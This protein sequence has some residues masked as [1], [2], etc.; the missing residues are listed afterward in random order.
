MGE[1]LSINEMNE[2]D[3][4]EQA[5]WLQAIISEVRHVLPAAPSHPFRQMSYVRGGA[6]FSLQ[7]PPYLPG[8]ERGA[9]YPASS[10]HFWIYPDATTGTVRARYELW[11]GSDAY[12]RIGAYENGPFMYGHTQLAGGEVVGQWWQ[13]I[14]DRLAKLRQLI[15]DKEEARRQEQDRR[16]RQESMGGVCRVCVVTMNNGKVERCVVFCSEKGLG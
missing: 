4:T 14:L 13:A 2:Q 3:R 7:Q 6:Q 16:R 10:I 9:L 5:R 12:A 1:Q 11:I 15:H 8:D